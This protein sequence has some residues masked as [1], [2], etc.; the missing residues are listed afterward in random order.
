MHGSL[1]LFALLLQHLAAQPIAPLKTAAPDSRCYEIRTYTAAPG[2]LEELLARFR[3]HTVK[4]FEKHGI[5][6]IGYWVPQDNK[7]NKLI[8]MI[9]FL[10]R[11]DR[12]KRFGEFGADPEWQRV[13]KESEANGKLVEKVESLM[14]KATD[15]TPEI[16]PVKDKTSA[17]PRSFELRIYK[18]AP[19]KLGDLNARFRD[20]TV[21]LFKKHGMVNFGYW[22]PLEKS[23]GADD[24]L[25]YLIVHKSRP[26]AAESWRAFASDPEWAAARDASEKNGKL[27]DKPPASIY[28]VPTDF[29][30]TS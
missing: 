24:T 20:H 21:A 27:L 12:D 10:N 25:V 11:D 13:Y 17:E 30:P 8:Y 1:L 26:A 15:Y 3:N 5:T 23:A 18:A 28:L 2:K 7:E 22:T 9:A 6:N 29:S 16:K 19:D 14:L 4:L